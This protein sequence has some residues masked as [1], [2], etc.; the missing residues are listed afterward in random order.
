MIVWEEERKMRG[1]RLGKEEI[2]EDWMGE[3]R[4]E[5][6]MG[7]EEQKKIDQKRRRV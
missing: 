2:E 7:R 1:D 5:K 3:E 6:K 4:V